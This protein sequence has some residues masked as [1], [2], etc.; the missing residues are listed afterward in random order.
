MSNNTIQPV[1]SDKTIDIAALLNDGYIIVCDTN[2][3]LGLYR[4]SPDYANFALECLNA[5]KDFIRLP[6]TVKI[7]YERHYQSMFRKRQDAVE[8]AATDLID[9]AKLQKNKLLGSF[10]TL[11]M[12]Q[13][14]D[15]EEIQQEIEDKYE[16]IAKLLSDYFEDRSVLG[17]LQGSWDRDIVKELMDEIC[18]KGQIMADFTRDEIYRICDEGEKRYKNCMPPGFKDSSRKDGIRKYSD[19]ILWKEVIKYAHDEQKN[20]IFVTDDV[21][22]DWWKA[23]NGTY[24]FLPEL[25]NEFQRKSRLR[26]SENNGI[27]GD[28]LQIVPFVSTDFYEAVSGSLHV[29]KS[30]A[31]DQAL[32]ITEESYIEAIADKA[33]DAAYAELQYSG[34]DYIDASIL[35]DIGSEGIEEWEI[36]SYDF[37]KY[38]ML[39]RA[40]D[41]IEYDLTY[42]VELRGYSHDYW[43]RDDDTREIVVSPPFAHS[44]KGLLVVRVARTVDIFMDFEYS[45]EFDSVEIVDAD[46][47]ETYFRS[48]YDGE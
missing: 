17:L 6:Y 11:V 34:T 28:A 25:V 36:E 21:K 31:V 23:G 47:E 7:E 35:T 8:N 20:V 42:E 27:A 10:S 19:L 4:F 45:D 41:I 40:D 2:V 33:I 43:G 22:V 12:K 14:P 26:E 5:V 32:Q 37:L 39:G 3:Y 44:V 1:Y 9:L 30:D 16:E 38:E 29:V 48:W 13:F 46:F 24:E 18:D 15:V